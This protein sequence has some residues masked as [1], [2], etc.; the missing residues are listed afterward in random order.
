[1]RVRQGAVL[2]LLCASLA[3]PAWAEGT[4]DAAQGWGIHQLML[5]LQ[6]VRSASAHFVERKSLH[7][8]KE[9]LVSSGTLLY[10]APDRLQKL[11]LEPQRER[12]A[13]SGDTLTIE[14][15]PEDRDR[16]LSLNDNPEIATFVEGIRATLAGDLPTLTR[17]YTVKF[18]GTQAGWQLLLE[19]KEDKA[20]DVVS[21]IRIS[22]SGDVIRHIETQQADGD[23]SDMSIDETVQ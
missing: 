20:K 8:L 15:G 3:L 4:S 9:P 12:M 19:P 1:M 16:T 13:V 18:D 7:M 10:A 14:G 21:W 17:L 23:H 11:T 22:G 5:G 6:Q 2:L